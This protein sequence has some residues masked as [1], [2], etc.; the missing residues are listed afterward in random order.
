MIRVCCRCHQPL[1]DE[2]RV[3]VGV[4]M[5][6]SGPGGP[7][8]YACLPCARSYAR[9]PLAPAWIGE[10]IANAETRLGGGPGPP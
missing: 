7:S 5:S 1:A 3:L 6:N 2:R 10:E 8:W 4:L 9:S